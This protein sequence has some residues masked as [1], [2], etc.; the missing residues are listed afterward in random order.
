MEARETNNP[1]HEKKTSNALKP[2]RKVHR[3]TFNPN[4]ASPGETLHISVPKL[5]DGVVLVPGSLALVFN[6]TV[7]GHA[8]NVLVNRQCNVSRALVNRM[9][10]EFAGEILQDTDG[11]DLIMLY[12]DLFLSEKER[13]SRIAEGNQS[14]HLSKIRCN[15]GDKKTSGVVKNV[16]MRAA[17]RA[18]TCHLTDFNET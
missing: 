2:D 18:A 15:A 11:Y 9:T 1:S 7:T 6:L 17:G 4:K 16:S 3:V 13:A 10:V 5:D 14:D 8:N 12:E